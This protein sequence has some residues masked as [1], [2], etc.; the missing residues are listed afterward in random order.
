MPRKRLLDL[1]LLLLVLLAGY[2]LVLGC[3][4][5]DPPEPDKNKA[6]ETVITV[7]PVDSTSTFYRVHLF[8]KGFDDDGL[9][10][11]YEYAIGDT[12]RRGVEWHFTAKTDSEFVFPTAIGGDQAQVK[13]HIFWVR[14]IDNEGKEDRTP[15]FVNFEAFTQVEPRSVIL[16]EVALRLIRSGDY[17][18]VAAG[19]NGLDIYDISNPDDI[20]RVRTVFTG[21]TGLDL[22]IRDNY[23]YIA[24][25][26]GSMKIVDI[27]DPP[28]S[29]LVGEYLTLG[30]SVTG[31]D[32]DGDFLFLAD[33][34][35]GVIAL[36]IGAPVDPVFLA[37]FRPNT[38]TPF[39]DVISQDG[40]VYVAADTAGIFALEF[41]PSRSELIFLPPEQGARLRPF[42]FRSSARSLHL[43]DDLLFVAD[44]REGL[45]TISLDVAGGLDTTLSMLNTGGFASDLITGD[46]VLYLADGSN[47]L[48][49][50][51]VSDPVNPSVLSRLDFSADVTGVSLDG[52]TLYAGN[53]DRG[54]IVL[55]VTDLIPSLV[56][57][58][59]LR[60]C[61]E[62]RLTPLGIDTLRS[63][64]E[65]ETLTA[66]S[67]VKFCWGGVSAGG[68]VIAYRY[69]MQG[70]DPQPIT[71]GP[72]TTTAI[73]EAL[74]PKDQ[75]QFSVETQDETGVWS[76]GEGSAR[77]RFTINYDPETRID[78]VK[79]LPANDPDVEEPIDITEQEGIRIPYLSQLFFWWSISDRDS[80]VGDSVVGSFWDIT[81][82][83]VVSPESLDSRQIFFST[84]DNIRESPQDVAHILNIGGIDSF[85]RREKARASFQFFVNFKPVV[86]VLSPQ[87]NST[88][89]P[90]AGNL[91]TISLNVTDV[92]GP[93]EDILVKY[94][95][96]LLKDSQNPQTNIVRNVETSPEEDGTLNLVINIGGFRGRYR[97]IV[98]PI[99][100]EGIGGAEGERRTVEFFVP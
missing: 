77:R 38:R 85:G 76:T 65:E 5:T 22:V 80:V 48:A 79:Y 33:G 66:F 46:G 89:V 98:T 69:Q 8:W 95:L 67:N 12:A 99:D 32:Q 42:N 13:D 10:R 81:G 58:P 9:I 31:I 97:F 60:F 44:G 18:F 16:R 24:D 90:E 71:V 14:A 68:K 51:D 88:L 28:N 27:S 7:G 57:A 23:A 82:T 84:I 78:S 64:A 3:E 45:W 94:S 30:R 100:L 11:G 50:I 2:L 34:R 49:T 93:N 73:Y 72:D 43:Q 41:D 56:I 91:I 75:Y 36:D 55:D 6:P 17:L 47:G 35:N 83:G 29:V 25:G 92:D 4:Q 87:E 40:L 70:F 63:P 26:E 61:F 39:L 19:E 54:F 52:S 74:T 37:R 96:I 20:Q 15:D 62:E 59:E 53:D 21:G 86:E 1:S